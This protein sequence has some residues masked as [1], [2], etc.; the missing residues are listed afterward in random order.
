MSVAMMGHRLR[1]RCQS[2]LTG[3]SRMSSQRR[4][5]F[6]AHTAGHLL[7]HAQKCTHVEVVDEVLERS[8]HAGHAVQASSLG[9]LRQALLKL[10]RRALDFSLAVCSFKANIS[11][12]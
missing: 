8:T 1:S 4:L 10:S 6:A 3:F 9:D 2:R 5:S 11:S 7:L 12:Y